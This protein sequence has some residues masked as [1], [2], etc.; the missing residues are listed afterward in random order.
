MRLPVSFLFLFFLGSALIVPAGAGLTA[1]NP[2]MDEPPGEE[3]NDS[4]PE[5]PEPIIDTTDG[6]VIDLGV[7]TGP[8]THC[9]SGFLWSLSYEEPHDSLVIPMKIQLF[10]SRITPWSNQTGLAS[11][12]RV[13]EF[14]PRIQIVLSDE[15]N[16]RFPYAPPPTHYG[17]TQF[18][19]N[20]I[21]SWPGDDG[22]YSLWKDVLEDA[23]EL[24]ESKGIDVEWDLWEEPNWSG[25]WK[26]GRE[27][28]F[29]TWAV[30]V[31]TLRELDPEAILVGPSITGF[32]EEY[33]KEFLAY[34]KAHEVLPDILSWHEIHDK[35]SPVDIPGHAEIMREYMEEN[36]IEIDHIDINEVVSPSRQT[37]PG[38]HVWYIANMEEAGIYGACKAT[39]RDQD[40]D[41]YNAMVPTLGG[42]L[43][44]PELKPRSTWWVMKAYGDITG[45]LIKVI[46]DHTME[47]IAGID[48]EAQTVRILLGRGDDA[49]EED[50]VKVRNLD[51]VSWFSGLDS[52]YVTARRIPDSGW[53]PLPSPVWI[54]DM[55]VA[56]QQNV[57]RLNFPEFGKNE[58]L[59][60][61]LKAPGK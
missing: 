4:V 32:D 59:E 60:I 1:C 5:P 11:I 51:K 10:R 29:E 61:V 53:D 24:I 36:E 6:A 46:P 2:I 42:Y 21:T 16:L 27:R 40:P 8:A 3:S 26:P 20:N 25:W 58:A 7:I 33:L 18:G 57:L 38:M 31:N 50:V 39:W 28:F 35:D 14:V 30:G 19:Y 54:M 43:T 22:D 13:S 12:L 17:K 45:K 37:N 47:G 48:E 49:S 34:A 44:Y 9:A 41:L 23:Y 55:N 52:I 15:Y 56:V